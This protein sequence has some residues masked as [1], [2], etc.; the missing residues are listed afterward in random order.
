M[1]CLCYFFDVSCSN[2]SVSVLRVRTRKRAKSSNIKSLLSSSS[3]LKYILIFFKFLPFLSDFF[4]NLKE[5]ILYYL[6][7]LFPKKSSQ[8]KTHFMDSFKKN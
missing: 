5:Q 4:L 8:K 3:I 7:S 2:S 6:K 1:P